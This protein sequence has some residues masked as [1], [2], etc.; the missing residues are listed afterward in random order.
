MFKKVEISILAIICLFGLYC[1]LIVGSSWDEIFQM[2]IGKERLKYIFSFGSYKDYDFHVSRFYPGFYDTLAI[3]VT[4]FFPIKYEIKIWHLTNYIFSIF[5]VFGI[6]KITSL[7][8]NKKVGK[9]VF[10][11]CILNPIFFGHMAMNAKDPLVAFAHVWST[12]IFLRYLQTQNS[13]KNCYRHILLAGLTLGFGTG[14]RLPFVITLA[15]LYLFAII[16]IIFLKKIT[17]PKFS[18]NKFIVDSLIVCLLAYLITISFWPQ[19]HANIFVKPFNLFMESFINDPFGVRFMLFNENI[20]ETS[21]LPNTYLIIN[22]FYKTP[23]FVLFSFIIFFFFLIAKKYF[24][25]SKFNFF[26]N[27]LLLILFIF[28]FPIFCFIF[29]PFRVYDGL[30]LFIYTIP[31]FTIIPGLSLYF[32]IDNFDRL[33]N[34]ILLIIVTGLFAYY[35]TIF[36]SITPYQYT[37]LNKFV[38]KFENAYKKFE[39]DYYAISTKE[40]IEKIPQ[41]TNLISNNKK[42]KISVCGANH[43]IIERQLN[44]LKKIKYE[45]KHLYAKDVDYV[46]MTNRIYYQDEDKIESVKSCFEKIKGRD[47]VKVE[48]NGLILSTI[49]ETR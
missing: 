19:V 46:I 32:L 2:N 11:L 43:Q 18:I 45:R 37:Y 36:V 10:L 4:K 26:W 31:Y 44:K 14:V 21:K 22:F 47:V 8:F 29:I 41:E 9:I 30:R 27:K 34:K 35:M 3:F 38:G 12:Y 17:N 6:Y 13:N 49:R 7:L 20:I 42:I 5:T 25:I 1:A 33:I 40:L 28:L 23:E 39:N 24:F 15:P 16:D 48:R